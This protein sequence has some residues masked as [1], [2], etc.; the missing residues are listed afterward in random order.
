MPLI[1]SLQL[2]PASFDR[3]NRL[4]EHYF[5]PSWNVVP[6]HVMLFH[7][8]PDSEQRGIELALQRLTAE[9]HTITLAVTR[10]RNLGRG[11]AYMLDSPALSALHRQLAQQWWDWLTPQDRQRYQ[12]HITVQNKVTPEIARET[13]ADLQDSWQ[14]SNI[15]AHALLLWQ[16][17]NGPWKHVRTFGFA[18]QPATP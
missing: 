5:P 17:C 9:Q 10:L 7:N 14:P 8:L 15:S 2:D 4:R 1:L 6:A 3:F 11:V 12:P 16:Y 18:A 13:L